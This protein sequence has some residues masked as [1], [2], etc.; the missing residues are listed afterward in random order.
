MWYAI[1]QIEQPAPIVR[2]VKSY[3]PVVAPCTNKV[4]NV[5][6]DA[7]NK[8]LRYKSVGLVKK[9]HIMTVHIIPAGLPLYM[10]K[11]IKVPKQD[12]FSEFKTL[13]YISKKT[14]VHFSHSGPDY[15]LLGCK[16]P[17]GKF[18]TV[19]NILYDLGHSYVPGTLEVV[20]TR[21]NDWAIKV[22]NRKP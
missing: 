14:G 7:G 19:Y 5:V 3:K 20:M 13:R 15:A 11:S 4:G 1:A 12:V 10:W 18:T 9:Q 21:P 16:I 2:Q 6:G 17:Y 8:A 22:M